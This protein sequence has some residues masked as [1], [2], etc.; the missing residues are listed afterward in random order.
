MMG[1]FYGLPAIAASLGSS[2][3]DFDYPA[4]FVATFIEE[5]KQR[6]SMPGVVFSINIPKATEEEIAGV[7]VE[8]MG[9]I[10]LRFAYE[11]SQTGPGQRTFRPRIGLATNAPEGTDTG[12]FM[13]DMITITPLLFDWTA[14]PALDEVKGW[15]LSHVIAR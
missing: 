7:A 1:A 12:A 6:P 14:Y 15:A 3:M 9:G 2:G 11:E 8:K 10:H 4:R 13:S 5:M